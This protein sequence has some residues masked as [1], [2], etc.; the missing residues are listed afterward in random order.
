MFVKEPT[1]QES[2]QD[3]Q[4]ESSQSNSQASPQESPQE[5]AHEAKQE[6]PQENLIDVCALT[7]RLVADNNLSDSDVDEILDAAR[8]R[9][10]QQVLTVA[11]LNDI[12]EAARGGTLT[13]T[14]EKIPLVVKIFAIGFIIAGVSSIISSA[15]SALLALGFVP[16]KA[17]DTLNMNVYATSTIVVAGI[18]T[19]AFVVHAFLNIFIGIRLLQ[20]YRARAG[21][22]L[23]FAVAAGAIAFVCDV[24]L[25]GTQVSV[26]PELAS[27]ALLIA[28]SV[29]LNPAIQRVERLRRGLR[30]IDLEAHAQAGTLGLADKGQGFI[31]LDFFNVFWTF[32]VCCFLGDI[33]EVMFHMVVVDPG[34]YQDRAGLLYGPFSPIYGLGAVFMTMALNRLKDK[35]IILLFA[36][37]TVIGGVFE[38]LVSWFME[39]GFGAI[40]W[41]YHD[42]WLG[43]VFDGRTC[44][45][46]AAMFGLLGVVWIRLLLPR[47]LKLINRIPWNKRVIVTTVCGVL[48]F[49]NCFM[50]LQALD[51]WYAR[52]AGKQ[53]ASPVEQF[54]ADYYPNEFMEN[55]F[56]SMTIFPDNAARS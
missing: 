33:V 12:L 52:V 23:W 22:L 6:C 35:N 49:V 29:Y 25:K 21:A 11:E 48:M 45:L 40:A 44:P 20:G 39:I 10:K 34:V 43:W 17:A 53:P 3:N 8:R 50:T 31:R 46:Y 55:R 9:Q 13:Q 51:N 15:F 54:Y 14:F 18:N 56:Q 16:D 2:K 47:L 36:V 28:F 5:N 7:A 4:Q 32:V 38:Y 30:D 27:I 42:Q 37:C 41:D 19:I 24:M 26:I 1:Q